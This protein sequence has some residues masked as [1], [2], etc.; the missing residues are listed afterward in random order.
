ML[1]FYQP[2]PPEDD[3][4]TWAFMSLMD[5]DVNSQYK[6]FVP[7]FIRLVESILEEDSLP[8]QI[9]QFTE[10]FVFDFVP[11]FFTELLKKNTVFTDDIQIIEKVLFYSVK[12]IKWSCLHGYIKDLDNYLPLFQSDQTFYFSYTA[13]YDS[14]SR[15][16]S[17]P[18]TKLLKVRSLFIEE[19]IFTAMCS[20]ENQ[21]LTEMNNVF[22]FGIDVVDSIPEYQHHLTV[23]SHFIDIF[24]TKLSEF[25]F[26]NE[27]FEQ[28]QCFIL[29]G[30]RFAV[31]FPFL[32]ESR[33]Y[34]LFEFF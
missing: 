16:V 27:N 1:E 25:P 13:S 2:D 6:Y 11:K 30:T 29:N 3:Y 7:D 34:P 10:T 26:S 23:E 9:S 22:R 18:S 24:I 32:S 8:S 20:L 19:G 33:I 12:L 5:I 15:W 14:Q 28:V 31:L 17:T 4:P 21:T